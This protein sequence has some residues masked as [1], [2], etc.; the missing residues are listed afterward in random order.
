MRFFFLN[1]IP[2]VIAGVGEKTHIYFT[3]L[4]D[5]IYKKTTTTNK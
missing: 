4:V 2:V 1:A 3:P 5:S